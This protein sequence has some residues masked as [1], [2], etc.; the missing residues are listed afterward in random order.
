MIDLG[1]VLKAEELREIRFL[2]KFGFV[3]RQF[4]FIL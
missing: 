3:K 1:K 2:G 4:L